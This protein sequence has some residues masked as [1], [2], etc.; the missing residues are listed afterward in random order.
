MIAL[1]EDFSLFVYEK[2]AKKKMVRLKNEEW[3]FSTMTRELE[4]AEENVLYIG[5]AIKEIHWDKIEKTNRKHICMDI[6]KRCELQGED[7]YEFHLH[8]NVLN[9]EEQQELTD[10]FVA[11]LKEK[12]MDEIVYVPN[13]AWSKS[14]VDKGKIYT[15]GEKSEELVQLLYNMEKDPGNKEFKL[16]TQSFHY[17]HDSNEYHIKLSPKN[18]S[19]RILSTGELIVSVSTKKQLLAW[20][21]EKEKQRE[22]INQLYQNSL[23]LF[24]SRTK[25]AN[26]ELNRAGDLCLNKNNRLSP[27]VFFR[28]VSKTKKGKNYF[29]IF[30]G[31][32]TYTASTYEKAE[33]KAK[34]LIRVFANEYRI[35][36][37][38]R[39][40]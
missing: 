10:D 27:I 38:V 37:L 40:P 3:K 25:I 23:E 29:S 31:S 24:T 33:K 22:K 11:Y 17:Y 16:R 18:N 1:F 9:E 19:L 2:Y 12:G 4:G 13:M 28:I 36:H 5:N 35:R 30:F 15:T 14:Y 39:Q 20:Q 34:E 26:V 8:T 7:V 21:T 6:V 32:D